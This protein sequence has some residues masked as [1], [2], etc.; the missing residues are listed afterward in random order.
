MVE[1]EARNF[2]HA[3]ALDR[4]KVSKIQIKSDARLV[5]AGYPK[6]LNE[7]DYDRYVIHNQRYVASGKYRGHTDK[8]GI[9]A[10]KFD[11]LD[12]ITWPDGMSGS[13]VFFVEDHP[14]AHFFGFLGML[15]KAHRCS[16]NAD[17]IGADII[18]RFLDTIIDTQA[19]RT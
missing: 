8:R 12:Q 7:I 10:L 9:H 11:D 5:V 18:F 15:I 17:F 19:T 4:L 3:A 2:L 6:C 1:A 13:P 16:T 14:E